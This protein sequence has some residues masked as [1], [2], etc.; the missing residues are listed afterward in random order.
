MNALSVSTLEGKPIG[1]LINDPKKEK[2]VMMASP[3]CSAVEASDIKKEWGDKLEIV[4][5]WFSE[6]RER[7]LT[8]SK[9]R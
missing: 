7:K 4:S 8:E 6:G 1:I 9:T 5:S 2:L 3:S